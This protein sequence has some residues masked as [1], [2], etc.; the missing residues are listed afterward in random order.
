MTATTLAAPG[1]SSSRQPDYFVGSSGIPRLVGVTNRRVPRP[2]AVDS[3]RNM[4]RNSSVP[5]GTDPV[6]LNKCLFNLT[7]RNRGST[8][9]RSGSKTE[10]D[11]AIR[12]QY[13]NKSNS[14]TSGS[15]KNNN[16]N[17]TGTALSV[18]NASLASSTSSTVITTGLSNNR[19]N[20][21]TSSH[22]PST[23]SFIPMSRNFSHNLGNCNRIN[24]AVVHGRSHSTLLSGRQRRN[25]AEMGDSN[26]F[27]DN[28]CGN[29]MM[30]QCR[31]TVAVRKAPSSTVDNR[32]N[33]Q[34]K[35]DRTIFGYNRLEQFVLPP[36]QI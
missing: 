29:G 17:S 20:S 23:S 5:V 13:S 7:V 1:N 34:R 14:S 24:S 36:L 35:Y 30:R 11:I 28:D 25:V 21:V 19:R 22:S 33:Y 27:D 12:N 2:V 26:R 6:K 8:G 9:A 10:S 18:P 16:S 15:N 31:F 32:L 4:N 3:G